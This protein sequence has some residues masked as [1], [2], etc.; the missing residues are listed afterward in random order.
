MAALQT[1][2]ERHDGRTS[3]QLRA[4]NVESGHLD[5]VDGSCKL[6][7]GS[8]CAEVSIVGPVSSRKHSD[9]KQIDRAHLCVTVHSEQGTVSSHE[10]WIRQQILSVFEHSILTVKYPQT[11]IYIQVN[12]CCDA[13]SDLFAVLNA[14]SI[15]LLDSGIDCSS[16]PISVCLGVVD[17]GKGEPKLLLFDPTVKE[18][19]L[20]SAF[21][22]LSFATSLSKVIKTGIDGD[23]VPTI[24]RSNKKKLKSMIASHESANL[25]GG[26]K[27]GN[28]D[29]ASHDWNDMDLVFSDIKGRLK[30][31]TLK[32]VLHQSKIC[33]YTLQFFIKQHFVRGFK[34]APTFYVEK[35][36]V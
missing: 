16:F 29:E 18:L 14:V 2:F 7:I 20:I 26:R 21:G 27:K 3:N 30:M 25:E 31:D 28:D 24:N 12:I 34:A 4:I 36:A 8:T 35:D 22:T 10:Q 1:E 17:R 33:S 5:S 6:S 11:T 9:S 13:G 15:A 23:G 32:E 19:D